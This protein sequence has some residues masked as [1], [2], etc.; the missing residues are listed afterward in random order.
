[1]RVYFVS[2]TDDTLRVKVSGHFAENALSKLIGV[3]PALSAGRWKVEI[4]TQYTGSGSAML[5]SPRMIEGGMIL[6]VPSGDV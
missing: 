4:K 1:M 3:I 6:T 5:K 2:E